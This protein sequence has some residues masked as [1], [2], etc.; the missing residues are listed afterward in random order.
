MYSLREKCV[1]SICQSLLDSPDT[2]KELIQDKLYEKTVIR[3]K[4]DILDKLFVLI[5]FI[6]SNIISSQVSL[7]N[8]LDYY[9]VFKDYDKELINESIEISETI[10]RNSIDILIYNDTTNEEDIYSD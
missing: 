4:K 5:P 7:Q 8:R 3:T 10:A 2:I 1:N 9:S 6:T